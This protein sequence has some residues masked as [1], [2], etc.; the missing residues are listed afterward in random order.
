MFG[1][2]IY[3][4]M[5]PSS[6]D[7]KSD[8]ERRK[9]I[10]GDLN[11]RDTKKR[12]KEL[13]KM[14]R[15]ETV[16]DVFD[17][18]P[19]AI[20][21]LNVETS[22]WSKCD[23]C[24]KQV[25]AVVSQDTH[26]KKYCYGCS[27][28]EWNNDGD[29]SVV[30]YCDQ[31]FDQL[32]DSMIE[33]LDE[34][35]ENPRHSLRK[36]VHTLY[37][38][39]SAN[40]S[41]ESAET[42]LR[43]TDD[44]VRK[45]QMVEWWNKKKMNELVAEMDMG[46]LMD[47]MKPNTKD[48]TVLM[49]YPAGYDETIGEHLQE[50]YYGSLYSEE[51]MAEAT[52]LSREKVL[53]IMDNPTKYADMSHGMEYTPIIA[54]ES[55][56]S[57]YGQLCTPVGW[58]VS[59]H[60][61]KLIHKAVPEIKDNPA[62]TIYTVMWVLRMV[63]YY[64][65]KMNTTFN[66]VYEQ[67]DNEILKGSLN[68]EERMYDSTT[69]NYEVVAM[70]KRNNWDWKTQSGKPLWETNVLYKTS[71][72][73]SKR[74]YE[75]TAYKNGETEDQWGNKLRPITEID[76]ALEKEKEI[77]DEM[78]RTLTD[79]DYIDLETGKPIVWLFGGQSAYQ[80][81]MELIESRKESHKKQRET[82]DG[83]LPKDPEPMV[84]PEPEQKRVLNPPRVMTYDEFKYWVKSY[85]FQSGA[86]YISWVKENKS[87]RPTKKNPYEKI[88]SE[89]ET[90]IVF[91]QLWC[92]ADPQPYYQKQGTWKGWADACGFTVSYISKEKL[93]EELERMI[94]LLPMMRE[95]TYGNLQSWF[96]KK[97]LT[98]HNDPAVREL[99]KNVIENIKEPDGI[100]RVKY[101][102][103]K[104][105]TGG[106]PTKRTRPDNRTP[107]QIIEEPMDIDVEPDSLMMSDN[108]FDVGAIFKNRKVLLPR[109]TP[110][111]IAEYNLFVDLTVKS[112][113]RA[114]LEN[115]LKTYND[116]KNVETYTLTELQN[117]FRAKFLDEYA[118]VKAMKVESNSHTPKIN[119]QYGIWVMSKEHALFCM[120][121]TGSGKTLM[122]ILSA[123]QQKSRFTLVFCPINI[124]PQWVREIKVA[125]P[126]V[127]ITEGFET[128]E[129]VNE[130]YDL[131][132]DKSTKLGMHF[133]VVNYNK[134]GNN[135]QNARKLISQIKT[136]RPDFVIIDE[137]QNVKI[138]DSYET[139][140]DVINEKRGVKSSTQR[141]NLEDVVTALRGEQ[142]S[143]FQNKYLKKSK[144]NQAKMV[145]KEK[146]KNPFN[147]MMLSATPV[148]N[149]VAEG[150]SLLKLLTG[151]DYVEL[152]TR[153]TLRNAYQLHQQYL[154]VMMRSRKNFNIKINGGNG[155]D[156]DKAVSVPYEIPYGSMTKDEFDKKGFMELE[157]MAT[158]ARLPYILKAING[159]PTVIYT[160]YVGNSKGEPD[161]ERIIATL[162]NAVRGKINPKTNK[163]YT[164]G[165]FYGDDKTGLEPF[166]N[167]EIDVL[168][169]SRSVAEGM[170]GLQ[171]VC[172][173]LILNGIP[174]TYA[175]LE[176]VVGRLDREGQ[177]SKTLNVHMIFARF[178]VQDKNGDWHEYEYDRK[179]K[180]D[181][182][183]YKHQFANCVVEGRQP[184]KKE[185]LE[186][187]SKKQKLKLM[188]DAVGKVLKKIDD[189]ELD[190]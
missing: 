98:S 136:Y 31:Y 11:L 83:L 148:V 5:N 51:S 22:A 146:R 162:E 61:E 105:L 77:V 110:K 36:V 150:L 69:V 50:L 99:A 170:D 127:R 140:K 126:H 157:Q 180:Y 79:D 109:N 186:R 159:E 143:H 104:Y 117:D 71:R 113:W 152:G 130:N 46:K 72:D 42:S 55:A 90:T 128:Q 57:T 114:C 45:A 168:I 149:S 43:D 49:N 173:N 132:K 190:D 182:I 41:N 131:S 116:V 178:D 82:I 175:E 17:N 115:E 153:N 60:I 75:L 187:M 32:T 85:N 53:D 3:K 161:S 7:W 34:K 181:R 6:A 40:L 87:E 119:Q 111:E 123:K 93:K 129:N 80:D 171:N 33:K 121:R 144:K 125:F 65:V 160:T 48:D 120:D 54:G 18:L 67:G 84:E 86:E 142:T 10:E 118:E 44:S 78:E 101:F 4:Q 59:F 15:T 189:G 25:W 185:E 28:L 37:T 21:K 38:M 64:T 145:D 156:P 176:Q 63:C 139:S 133:H 68:H 26:G 147:V 163:P 106:K 91:D 177:K 9:R 167:G 52:G 102:V 89:N 100:R 165:L 94:E 74:V 107:Q 81:N 103:E 24:N 172:H 134:I 96:D 174:F 124:I 12:I 73:G 1:R 155:L 58:W 30:K 13:K 66:R 183:D 158:K 138:N 154:P 2:I 27:Q 19:T 8:P 95:W 47:L 166:L 135:R 169:A 16:A 62:L 92:P 112:I 97:G 188:R 76:V 56:K 70:A 179:V 184:A 14:Q 20:K 88:V 164:T 29:K 35:H 137:A 108:P 122:A 23:K 151:G 141:R 39:L